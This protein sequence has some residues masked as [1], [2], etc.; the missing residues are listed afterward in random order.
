MAKHNATAPVEEWKK[1]IIKTDVDRLL[2]Y[3]T[4]KGSVSEKQISKDLGIPEQTIDMWARALSTSKLIEKEYST[5][6]VILKIGSKNRTETQKKIKELNQNIIKKIK[7]VRE[8]IGGESRAVIEVRK[9]LEKLG[10]LLEKDRLESHYLEKRIL[11]LKD[12]QLKLKKELLKDIQEER[13]VE[14]EISSVLEKIYT[15]L[16]SLK[17]TKGLLNNFMEAKNKLD[18]DLAALKKLKQYN[19]NIEAMEDKTEEINKKEREITHL[20]KNTMKSLKKIFRA[21]K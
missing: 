18:Q 6:G 4:D 11:S 20:F 3:L 13:S 16:S 17:E 21:K 12:E 9:E 1:I 7:E 5:R 15:T 10:V 19:M 8:K 2:K 14:S